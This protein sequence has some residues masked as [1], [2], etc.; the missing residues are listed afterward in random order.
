LNPI[1]LNQKFKK[2]NIVF[3]IRPKTFS[4]QEH[5]V[6]QPD[7][8]FLFCFQKLAYQHAQL[9][10]AFAAQLGPP[11]IVSSLTLTSAATT[12]RLAIAA[13]L[14]TSPVTVAPREDEAEL[15]SPHRIAFQCRPHFTSQVMTPWKNAHR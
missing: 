15:P 7:F 5:R 9:V 10:L 6:A 4:A 14:C 11:P 3:L 13:T 12:A 1:S 8:L 2:T